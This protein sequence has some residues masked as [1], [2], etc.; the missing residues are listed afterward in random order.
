MHFADIIERIPVVSVDAE[1]VRYFFR[2]AAIEDQFNRL[3]PG[4]NFGACWQMVDKHVRQYPGLFSEGEEDELLEGVEILRDG[5]GE[6]VIPDVKTEAG[7]GK[8]RQAL[9]TLVGQMSEDG[10]KHVTQRRV[11]K[12]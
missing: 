1:S 12:A 2:L 7:Q 8:I 3:Y 4:E 11:G 9:E 10:N 6:L 5:T